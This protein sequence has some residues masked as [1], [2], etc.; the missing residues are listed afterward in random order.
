MVFHVHTFPG[1]PEKRGIPPYPLL[2][3]ST[4]K[5]QKR[6][7]ITF[8]I[9]YTQINTPPGGV[10]Y[11]QKGGFLAFFRY[12][13]VFITSLWVGGT[14]TASRDYRFDFVELFWPGT[15]MILLIF[16]ILNFI[17]WFSITALGAL[18]SCKAYYWLLYYTLIYLTILTR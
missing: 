11:P 12:F 8:T 4:L 17:F 14:I 9:K 18:R 13:S 15:A 16:Q 7:S 3:D 10:K 2:Q 1:F 6:V 5:R